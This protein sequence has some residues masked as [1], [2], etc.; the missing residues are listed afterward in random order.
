MTLQ[1]SCAT[2]GFLEENNGCRKAGMHVTLNARRVPYHG[3]GEGE[4]PAKICQPLYPTIWPPTME[5]EVKTWETK[6]TSKRIVCFT[7]RVSF[8]L[9]STSMSLGVYIHKICAGAAFW[10]R[11][12][13]SL[14]T[15]IPAWTWWG[16]RWRK[17]VKMGRCNLP[18]CVWTGFYLDV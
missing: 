3:L 4:K 5:V 1:K 7:R 8:P 12:T 6:I 11:P 2:C 9:F 16:S 17:M 15:L 18:L 14:A 10:Q 13:Q